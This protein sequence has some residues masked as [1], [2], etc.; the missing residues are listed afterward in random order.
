MSQEKEKQIA[1]DPDLYALTAA[2]GVD[3]N[4]SETTSLASSIYRGVMEN[5]RR[6]QTIREGAYWGPSDEQQFE[7]L[8]AGHL[9]CLVTDSDAPNPLFRAPVKD[10][11]RVLDI[12]T[13]QGSWAVD[14]ADMFPN[15]TVYGVDLYPP[16]VTWMPPN[17][18][19]EVDD[20]LQEW[21]WREPFDFIHMRLMLGAFSSQEWDRV[22]KQCYDNLEPGGWF[23]QLEG[24]CTV[25]CDDGSLPKDSILG[26]WGKNI[27]A[28]ANNAGKPLET[29]DTMGQEI[30]KAGFVDLHEKVYKWPIGPWPRDPVLKESGRLSY[31]MWRTGVDG[32]AMFLLT[33]YGMPEPWS[34]EEVQV[35]VAKAR[36]DLQNPNYHGYIFARR[37]WGRKPTLEE[38]AAKNAK[39]DKEAREAKQAREAA[40]VKEIKKEPLSPPTST[41]GRS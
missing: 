6:Y 27:C 29:L 26:Q 16:P 13:G 12:G 39:E 19:L 32:W 2:Y 14:M 40:G 25:H 18:I 35:Y 17:C 31:H 38:V 36:S 21:T 28:A 23:E 15:S 37:I 20:V 30:E 24:G 34:K 22:Y 3:D 9:V 10:P 41:S 7:T 4:Q 5:G 8:E 33:K 11:Q 1:V